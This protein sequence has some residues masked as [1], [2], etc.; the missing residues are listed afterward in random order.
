MMRNS[1]T[2][3]KK[4]SKIRFKKKLPLTMPSILFLKHSKAKNY[5]IK[6]TLLKN[7]LQNKNDLIIGFTNL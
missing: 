2:K 6:A 4:I 7:N 1:K 3:R 5:P